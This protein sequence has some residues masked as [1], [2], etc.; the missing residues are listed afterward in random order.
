MLTARS[1]RFSMRKTISQTFASPALSAWSPDDSSVRT[2]SVRPAG[3]TPR[4]DESGAATLEGL[5]TLATVASGIAHEVNNPLA[6]VLTNLDFVREQLG[7]SCGSEVV[8][9]L[10]EAR[11]G[12]LRIGTIVRN[13]QVVVGNEDRVVDIGEIAESACMI[14]QSEVTDGAKVVRVR[15]WTPRVTANPS[16]VAYLVLKMLTFVAGGSS[17][18]DRSTLRV[19]TGTDD[20]GCAAVLVEGF[21]DARDGV[22]LDE[23]MESRGLSALAAGLGAALTA[24]CHNRAIA[25]KLAF[26]ASSRQSII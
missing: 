1:L 5:S 26:P 22:S 25:L 15:G 12:A 11:L 2:A 24:E 20:D 9:A 21:C 7:S 6:Y 10:E 18:H 16:R 13:L 14:V 17:R 3:L 4:E 23:A 8:A 19:A